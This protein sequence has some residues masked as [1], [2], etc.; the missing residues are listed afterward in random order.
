MIAKEN[1]GRMIHFRIDGHSHHT[2]KQKKQLQVADQRAQNGK[3]ITCLQDKVA[4]LIFSLLHF[5]LVCDFFIREGIPRAILHPCGFAARLPA[6]GSSKRDR[7]VEIHIISDEEA[8]E[9]DSCSQPW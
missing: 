7:R 2:G 6:G 3:P 9:I 5:V 4:F 8:Q 1:F